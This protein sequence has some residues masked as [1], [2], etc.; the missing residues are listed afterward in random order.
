MYLKNL[1]MRGFKSFAKKTQIIFEPGLSVL[2]GPNGCGKSNIVDAVLWVLGEQNPRFLRGQAMTDVIFSGSEL[3]KPSPFAEVNLVFDNSDTV[4]PVEQS[5]VSIKR[6]VTCDGESFYFVNERPCRL[7][8]IRDL[9]LKAGLGDELPGIVSQNRLN[10][11]ISPNS[12]DL[13]V[14]IEEAS[15]IASYR[16][17]KENALKRMASVGEK[18]EKLVAIKNE[19]EKETKPLKKQV[20]KLRAA[21]EIKRRLNELWL[22]VAVSELKLLKNRYEDVLRDETL[23]ES[24]I[25]DL[26]MKQDYLEER[27]LRFEKLYSGL[28]SIEEDE[29]SRMKFK[30]I[31]ERMNVHKSV[32]EEKGKNIIEKFSRLRQELFSLEKRKGELEQKVANYLRSAERIDKELGVLSEESSKLHERLIGAKGKLRPAEELL[33]NLISEIESKEE[34][35][36]KIQIEKVMITSEKEQREKSFNEIQKKKDFLA[37]SKEIA[38]RELV[39]KKVLLEEAEK[40]IEQYKDKLSKL[41]R[42]MENQKERAATLNTKSAL[43]RSKTE[44][45]DSEM[46][47][48]KPLIE[49]KYKPQG[50]K[51]VFEIVKVDMVAREAVSAV[52]GDFSEAFILSLEEAELAIKEIQES[53]TSFVIDFPNSS[54]RSGNTLLDYIKNETEL[55]GSIKRLL[56]SYSLVSNLREAI[57]NFKKEPEKGYASVDG[58]IVTPEG[59]VVL[60]RNKKSKLNVFSEIEALNAEQRK[61][62]EE[63][64]VTKS[65]LDAVT[66]A[67]SELKKAIKKKEIE[68]ERESKKMGTL[69]VEISILVKEIS[70]IEKEIKTLNEKEKYL[71]S[72]VEKEFLRVTALQD[73]ENKAEIELAEKKARRIDASEKVSELRSEILKLES[74]LKHIKE[75]IEEKSKRKRDID[76]EYLSTKKELE[77]TIES[78]S[79]L[80]FSANSSESV[81]KK[82]TDI[83]Q[84]YQE[85]IELIAEKINQLEGVRS[86]E[87]ERFERYRN[88]MSSIIKESKELTVQ[89][90]RIL[91][92][93]EIISSQKTEIETKVKIKAQEILETTGL[94]MEKAIMETKFLEDELPRL[95]AAYESTKKEYDLIGDYNP[96]AERDYERLKERSDFYA[97]Q[98][99]DLKEAAAN[100]A[101][102]INEVDRRIENM[103]LDVFQ[104]LNT[105]FSE[106]F[107]YLF[108]GGEGKLLLRESENPLESSIDI[109]AQPSGK[110]PKRLSLLSGGEK[111]MIALAL[112][113][114]MEETF[115]IP[116]LL[117]DEVEPALDE[118]NLNRL[119]N[120]L[121][122]KSEQTQIIIISHQAKTIEEADIVYGVT[123]GKNG[124]SSI[125]CQ[126]FSEVPT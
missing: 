112:I 27:R 41:R 89:M 58:T 9:I 19:I 32:L 87:R 6:R 63:M 126:R 75:L 102:I 121:K 22:A 101:S 76:E 70:D 3:E 49:E 71:L 50:K 30:E 45:L 8:D 55:P 123:M 7:S 99:S 35:I 60:Q 62:L 110:K 11:L 67:V 82:L 100:L 111:S 120:L 26:K 79:A 97:K 24:T 37:R 20:E 84:L 69:E 80:R 124:V 86:S 48:F 31:M 78:I 88:E 43:L 83:H 59:I 25:T 64:E 74:R 91:S 36:K 113:F 77:R 81:R 114:A 105:R 10:E 73:E 109:I 38:E 51:R 56:D 98:I 122:R 85:Y 13:R 106:L 1:T 5:E 118:L 53:T 103:F 4:F 2:I 72:M 21:L 33:A 117:L 40:I 68:V 28:E 14:I 66:K 29:M 46:Q 16:K 92:R 65:E 57:A 17:R 96:L 116:F 125:Y 34:S 44:Q 108:P 90:E 52:L 107:S 47:K 95:R 15:G 94:T 93:K 23:A 39:E 12:A 119:V 42:K 61:V 54:R 18:I 115:K 104:R